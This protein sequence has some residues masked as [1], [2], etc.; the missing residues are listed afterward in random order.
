MPRVTA[1]V[2]DEQNEWLEEKSGDSG[3]YTSK[4][5]VL[6]ECINRY[7]EVEDLQMKVN[8]LQNEKETLIRQ[9]EEHTALVEFARQEMNA[10]QRREERRRQKEQEPV[11]IRA[12]H[13]V[14]G[15]E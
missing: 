9:K 6:R 14:F 12:R 3:E 11:W 5:E 7:E 8:R 2:S 1:T 4:S 15:R 13:W 10:V